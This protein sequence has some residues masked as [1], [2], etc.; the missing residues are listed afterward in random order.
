[1]RHQQYTSMCRLLA[2]THKDIQHSADQ[3]RFLRILISTDPVQKQLDLSE[4]YSSLRTRLDLPGDRAAMVVENYQADYDDNKGDA[5]HKF[6]HS[7]FMILKKVEVGDF[8]GRDAAIDETE[9]IGEELIA[10]LIEQLNEAG[11][12]ITPA[13][14]MQEAVGP[15]NQILV[16]CRFNYVFR[17]SARRALTHNPDNYIN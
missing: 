6:H 17:S 12:Y 1:M 14:V 8:D 13:E 15:I 3:C 7:S 4:F 10:T 11:M 16:G 2:S 9:R 5:Y